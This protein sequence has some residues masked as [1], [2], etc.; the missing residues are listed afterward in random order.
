M[1]FK[2]EKTQ[3]HIKKYVGGGRR[4]L[5]RSCKLYNTAAITLIHIIRVTDSIIIHSK[6]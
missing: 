4:D 6:S 5:Q 3:S 1:L 2:T